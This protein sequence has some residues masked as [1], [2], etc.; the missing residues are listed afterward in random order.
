MVRSTS[1]IVVGAG[2]AGATTALAL[3]RQGL[4]V[5]L[6]DA[7]EPGHS[8]A[9]SGGEHR[10]LR[11]SHGDDDFYAQMSREARVE[12]LELGQQTGQELFVESGAMM[13]AREGHSV[14]E[15]A[16]RKSLERLGIPHFVVNPG[17]L[18]AR[19]PVLNPQGV[20]YALW[21]P[22]SGFVYAR[23]GTLAAISQ[24]VKEGG[25]VERGN[26]TTNNEERPCLDGRPLQADVIVVTCGAW[27]SGLFPRTLRRMLDVV[28]QNV[29][30]IAPP[31]G[32]VRFDHTHFPAWI[33][34]GY[35]AYGI[36]AAGGFGFKA[37]L[38]WRELAIDLNSD[39]RTVDAT[40]IARTRRYLSLRFPALADRPISA[41][42]VGQ[43][44]NTIDT[45][46]IIDHHPVHSDV[47]MVAG[48][49]G[50]LFKHGPTIG[51]YIADVA[52]HRRE[53]DQRFT[54]GQRSRGSLASRPQ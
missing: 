29:I 27:M 3:R 46:F 8:G 44:A 36:P 43:I 51:R 1:A 2:I 54:L 12:W 39:D 34:H 25:G 47:V 18:A 37:V 24:F 35:S 50:H 10:V 16:S 4:Q 33:D 20:S 22:E 19:L 49:S 14:W 41:V 28:R 23:R 7:W 48:D 26:V 32:E 38:V 45:H 9:A 6:L 15:D 52:T 53:T 13:L 21:E 42:A 30:M 11:A 17:E 5:R 40:S 31:A